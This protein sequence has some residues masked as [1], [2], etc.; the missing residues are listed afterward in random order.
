MA[1]YSSKVVHLAFNQT[2]AARTLWW[3]N[4]MKCEVLV[5][6][7]IQRTRV[8]PITIIHSNPVYVTPGVA[9]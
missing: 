5:I 8:A 7:R 9:L 6:I 3:S 2:G 1:A 4:N